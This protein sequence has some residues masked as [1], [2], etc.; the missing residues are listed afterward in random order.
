EAIPSKAPAK[1]TAPAPAAPAKQ[2]LGTFLL[3][4]F[5]AGLAAIFTPCVFPMI[6]ITMS[7]FLKKESTTR[8]ASIVQ[9]AV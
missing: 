1:S 7:F 3:V 4:A 6:P 5:G 8:A 2:P 9:A